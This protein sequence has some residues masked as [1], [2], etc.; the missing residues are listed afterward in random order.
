[1]VLIVNSQTTWFQSPFQLL[2]FL[3]HFCFPKKITEQGL[4]YLFFHCRSS[5][6]LVGIHLLFPYLK[7]PEISCKYP[8]LLSKS[9]IG[10]SA[11]S[12]EIGTNILLSILKYVFHSAKVQEIGKHHHF[13]WGDSQGIFM[14]SVRYLMPVTAE[15]K[16]K[17]NIGLD[18][19][20]LWDTICHWN[21]QV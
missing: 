9:V 7:S 15:R 13:I 18:W 11:L 2:L 6:W 1:M 3:E 16:M 21:S 4:G 20:G 10:S 12:A 8:F 5:K 17:T 14:E 19:C